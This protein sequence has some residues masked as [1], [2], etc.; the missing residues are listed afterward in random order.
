M[1]RSFVPKHEKDFK[2][3]VKFNSFLAQTIPVGFP[4]LLASPRRGCLDGGGGG[5]VHEGCGGD[6]P[7]A[8]TESFYG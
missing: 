2:V 4:L 8:G 1:L 3:Q 6:L 5:G 7:G